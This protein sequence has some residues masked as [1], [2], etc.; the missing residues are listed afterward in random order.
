MYYYVLIYCIIA[1]PDLVFSCYS[2]YIV[3]QDLT[4]KR[5]IALKEEEYA[6]IEET[7]FRAIEYNKESKD[8]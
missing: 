8:E 5:Y 1:A 7:I 3:L 2:I 6:T 4:A